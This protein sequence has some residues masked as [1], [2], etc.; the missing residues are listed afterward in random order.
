MTDL[1]TSG[2]LYFELLMHNHVEM[3]SWRKIGLPIGVTILKR[4]IAGTL[5]KSKKP[6]IELVRQGMTLGDTHVSKCPSAK[7]LSH[8][9]HL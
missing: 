6:K 8:L 1:R 9:N 7:L 3:Q 2:P 4:V 5:A